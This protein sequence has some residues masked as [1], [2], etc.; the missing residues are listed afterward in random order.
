MSPSYAEVQTKPLRTGPRILVSYSPSGPEHAKWLTRT[1]ADFAHN[2]ELELQ[3][4]GAISEFFDAGSAENR[5]EDVAEVLVQFD[6]LLVLGGGDID[7]SVYGNPSVGGPGYGVDRSADEAEIALVRTAASIGLPVMGIC[8][9]LQIINVA[10]GGNLIQDLGPKSIH[11]VHSTAPGMTDH[12]VSIRPGS[13]LS[14]AFPESSVSVRSGHHQAVRDLGVGL[15][16][17]AE[18]PDGVIEAI[19]HEKLWILGVQWHPEDNDTVPGQLASLIHAFTEQCRS[20]RRMEVTANSRT[21]AEDS[22]VS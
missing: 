10:F 5:G 6:G 19:E 2:V 8:R 17:A 9:G 18:A 3:E 1:L 15:F 22:T 14:R 16:A 20:G 21:F 13:L 4:Q 12:E 7:S 11:Q